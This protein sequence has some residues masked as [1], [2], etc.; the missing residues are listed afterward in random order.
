MPA[1]D[2]AGSFI[3]IGFIL[4]LVPIYFSSAAL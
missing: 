3:R 4:W 2:F 1:L